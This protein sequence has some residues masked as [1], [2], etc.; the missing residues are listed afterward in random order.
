MKHIT[1]DTLIKD[2]FNHDDNAKLIF[3]FFSK[4][5]MKFLIAGNIY[6]KAT[7]NPQIKADE[8]NEKRLK[9]VCEPYGN[10][11]YD[12]MSFELATTNLINLQSNV[13]EVVYI[14]SRNP[15]YGMDESKELVQKRSLAVVSPKQF[16]GYI[17]Y[18]DPKFIEWYESLELLKNQMM[19]ESAKAAALSK[20]ENLQ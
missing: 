11:S 18:S 16:A 15:T 6:K 9:I 4:T 12:S 13:D 8:N 17:R 2:F 19:D 3:A 10:D 20:L 1:D 14:T 7:D 5:G